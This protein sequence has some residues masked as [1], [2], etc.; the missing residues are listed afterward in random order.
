MYQ[1]D[2]LTLADRYEIS[3]TPTIM[4]P[5]H[6]MRTGI[7]NPTLSSSIQMSSPLMSTS[8][9]YQ[10]S[11]YQANP[12]WPPPS[13]STPFVQCPG[14]QT[15]PGRYWL[16]SEMTIPF[17][18]STSGPLYDDYESTMELWHWFSADQI[19]RGEPDHMPYGVHH[20]RNA[21]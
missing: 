11:F 16:R 13:A 18:L 12:T 2:W 15:K 3:H 7:I 9:S 20:L 19:L 17:T 6:G 10:P 5:H 1:D 8:N 4:T 14:N 21:P